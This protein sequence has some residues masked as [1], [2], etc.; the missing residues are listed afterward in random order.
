M[1]PGRVVRGRAN[2]KY[3]KFP[4]RLRRARKAA[5]L[6][7]FTLSA[8][9]GIG[10]NSVSVLEEGEVCPRLPK[11]EQL[12]RA[13]GL[14]PAWL[15]FGL[16]EQAAAEQVPGCAGFAGRV[17]DARAALGLSA[18][19]VDR[20]AGIGEGGVSDLAVR[21]QPSLDTLEKLA[22]ALQVSPAW[23]AFGQGS[24]VMPARSRPRDVSVPKAVAEKDAQASSC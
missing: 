21:G 22:K 8:A 24:M 10:K 3:W 23:L 4:E 11:V 13:L 16:G 6:N 18:R 20:R 5:G 9:A 17:R 7:P 19:E 1:L 2:P 12:A 15:A 14:S